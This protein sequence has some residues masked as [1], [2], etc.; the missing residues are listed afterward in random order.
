MARPFPGTKGFLCYVGESGCEG[1]RFGS[2]SS[3]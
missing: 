2:G 1:F 3:G